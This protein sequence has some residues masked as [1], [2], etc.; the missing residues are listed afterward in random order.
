MVSEQLT[1]FLGHLR[2]NPFQVDETPAVIQRLDEQQLLGE[3]MTGE[4]TAPEFIVADFQLPARRVRAQGQCLI[5]AAKH[6][7]RVELNYAAFDT[8]LPPTLLVR[9]E[10]WLTCLDRD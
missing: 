8:P 10:Q 5:F 6:H 4:K 2:S 1:Q 9:H 7:I 3:L